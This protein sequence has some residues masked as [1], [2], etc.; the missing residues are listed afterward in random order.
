MS[1]R[2]PEL[3][4]LFAAHTRHDFNSLRAGCVATV[5]LREGKDLPLPTGR[6]AAG[7]PGAST[8]Y[9]A[10]DYASFSGYRRA[11]TPSSWPWRISTIQATPG[12]YPLVASRRGSMGTTVMRTNG[13][14]R[15]A[16][17][18]VRHLHAGYQ[19]DGNL[20][21]YRHD[22]DRAVWTSDTQGASAGELVSRTDAHAR[23]I[24][25]RC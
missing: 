19:N 24:V 25:R 7:E 12:R 20:V 6:L 17:L 11:P 22:L 9:D 13:S 23:A 3:N 21:L 16:H 10:G 15:V 5:R 1:P 4:R 18:A 2:P 14:P 8:G